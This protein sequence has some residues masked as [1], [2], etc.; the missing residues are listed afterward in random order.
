MVTCFNTG[1]FFIRA[2]RSARADAPPEWFASLFITCVLRLLDASL[3]PR[4]VLGRFDV[5]E[6]TVDPADMPAG[7]AEAQVLA[8]RIVARSVVQESIA[9]TL[10]ESTVPAEREVLKRMLEPAGR[11]GG[12][13]EGGY[14]R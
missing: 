7:T 13:D 5:V 1:G 3:G 4:E 9:R 12:S 10:D 11:H 2:G 6:T 14:S 8:L